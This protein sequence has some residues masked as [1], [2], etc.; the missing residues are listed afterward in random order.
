MFVLKCLVFLLISL[1]SGDIFASMFDLV[2]VL[3]TQ[4]KVSTQVFNAKLIEKPRFSPRA[5]TLANE[6]SAKVPQER[7]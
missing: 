1:V 2:N 4:Q 6:S 5:L 3:D 7:T